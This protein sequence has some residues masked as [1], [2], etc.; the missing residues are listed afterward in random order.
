[1]NNLRDVLKKVWL[2]V[3]LTG[4]FL[5]AA[6]YLY[7]RAGQMERPTHFSPGFFLLVI[8]T[9]S[10]FWYTY[11]SLWR[12]LLFR[13]ATTDFTLWESFR[14]INLL[15]L[16]KYL[17][18]KIWGMVAR[19]A[20]L[21]E[22]GVSVA[23]AVIATCTEQ[24]LVL[25]S[26]L[27]VSVLLFACLQPSYAAIA[28]AVLSAMTV[29]V[30]AWLLKVALKVYLHFFKSN[31]TA[32]ALPKPKLI[33]G[34]TYFTF[35]L[36]HGAGWIFNGLLFSSIYYAFFDVAPTLQQVG[37]LVLANTVGVTIGFLAIFAPGGIGV[38]EAITSSILTMM[39]SIE[40]A[41]MLA[42][43]FRLWLLLVDM[44]VGVLTLIGRRAK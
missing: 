23:D 22:K 30:G 1:M 19:G 24:T 26:A 5:Y 43:L 14:Q 25:H 12:R 11:S 35:I 40:D 39:M 2:Y 41:V 3:F 15:N 9:Q 32:S 4:A 29:G 10:L 44:I 33:S 16:G 28:F 21:S 38:R 6:N 8:A 36:G 42:V 17:P 27:I 18:G 7:G 13:V 31:S 20:S 34:L 37:L